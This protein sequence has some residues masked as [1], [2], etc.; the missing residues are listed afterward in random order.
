MV[1]YELIFFLFSRTH[2]DIPKKYRKITPF[3]HMNLV[4]LVIP[5][6]F[7]AID[8]MELYRQ[9]MLYV[10][11]DNSNLKISHGSIFEI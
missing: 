3:I 9:F 6:G 2:T 8:S 5:I 1:V 11:Q 10:N 4:L 7:I